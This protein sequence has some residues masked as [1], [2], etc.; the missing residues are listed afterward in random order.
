MSEKNATVEVCRKL[1]EPY[2]ERLG[3]TLWD[4]RFVKE[5]AE[6]FLRYLIDKPGGVTVEDCADLSRLLSPALDE[7]DPIEQS[8]CLEVMSPGTERELRL[9]QHF[10]MCLGLPVAVKLYRPRDGVREFRGVLAR[11]TEDGTVYLEDD[12]G[13]PMAFAKADIA[14][15]RLTDDETF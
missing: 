7:A 1:A 4:V 5:G 2:V 6:W 12:A 9:P 10:E 15:V 8:Y 13:C 3:L 11:R 14:Q